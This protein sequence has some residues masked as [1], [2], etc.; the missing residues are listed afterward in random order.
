[1]L[2]ALWERH[3][4][5]LGLTTRTWAAGLIDEM[6]EGGVLRLQ[7]GTVLEDARG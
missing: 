2:R 4:R 7:A 1:M 6:V 5:P 3:G